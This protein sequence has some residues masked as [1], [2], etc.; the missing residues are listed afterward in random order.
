MPNNGAY[1]NQAANA[2]ERNVGAVGLTRLP[3][4]FNP[5]SGVWLFE[6]DF[7][8]Q[9]D[10]TADRSN[11]ATAFSWSG[12]N[13]P[14]NWDASYDSGGAFSARPNI[15]IRDSVLNGSGKA[16]T[17]WRENVVTNPAY[18]SNGVLG[19]LFAQDY[20]ELYIEFEIA[21][22]SGWTSGDTTATSK[23]FRVFSSSRDQIDFWQAFA[24]GEQGPLFLWD[25]GVS[26]SYGLRNTILFRGGPH[27]ENYGMSDADIGNIG[28]SIVSGSLGD[29]SM[30]W[31]DDMNRDSLADGTSPQIPDKLNGGFLPTT[32]SVTH[33]QVYGVA[34]TFTKVGIYVKMNSAP[35]VADG[36]FR[37]YHDD[38]LIVDSET[39]RWVDST[40]AP[41]PGWNAFSLGGNDDWAG[42]I[43]DD[44][45]Q[46]EEFYEI[47]RVAVATSLPE[48][49]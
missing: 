46:R 34:G 45:D 6:E 27:G 15:E 47:R 30:N 4:A 25:Y 26:G 31:T 39:V 12:G 23:I 32:G 14:T 3:V 13:L 18:H 41:M 48:G 22:Q 35:G 43:W 20:D 36:I 44:A 5:P 10:W 2:G 28:R 49:L 17:V 11:G 19:K 40:S 24:N 9:A 1:N 21:F 33:E 37:Q 7:S 29:I 42:G 8:A 38:R 16:L